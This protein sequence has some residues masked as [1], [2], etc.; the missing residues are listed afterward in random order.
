MRIEIKG[1]IPSKKNSKMIVC[2]GKFPQVLPSKSY[3]EWH[4]EAS[5]QLVGIPRLKICPKVVE[6]SFYAPDKRATDLTNK[7]ESVMDLLVDNG[8][9]ED[10]NWFCC[11]F[12]SLLFMGVDKENPR[13]IVDLEG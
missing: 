3:T 7:A 5:R 2:R 10:D 4:K 9:I 13:V 6:L 12:I 1:R 11:G 8:V